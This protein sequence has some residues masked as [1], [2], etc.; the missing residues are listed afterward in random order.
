M[1]TTN[2]AAVARIWRGRTTPELADAY[3]AYS[4]EAGIEPLI[5][6]A[7]A[8]DVFREDREDET[9]FVTISYWESVEAMSAFAGADPKAIHHL[10]RDP[11]FLIELPD[12]VQI[13]TMPYQVCGGAYRGGRDPRPRLRRIDPYQE[14]PCLDSD[15]GERVTTVLDFPARDGLAVQAVRVDYEPGGYTAGTHRHPAGAYVYVVDGSVI[16]GIDEDEPF[17]LKAGDSFYEPPGA[18]HAVSRN[19][20]EEVPASLLA[21]FVLGD[22]REPDRLRARRAGVMRVV[23]LRAP[24]GPEQLAIEEAEQP[25]PG[26][27]QA[28]V[29]VHAAAITRDEL[30]WP[31]ERLPAIPSYELS[32]V[33]EEVGAD[34]TGVAVGDDVFALTPFDRDGVAADYAAVSA[35][36]LVG[37]PRTLEH[38]ESAAIPLPALSAWQGLFDHGR[39]AAGQRVLIHGAAG[40]V[41]AFA[42]QLARA[43]GA[44]VIGT[45]SAANLELV[46]RARRTRGRRRD[47]EVRGRRR[48]GRRGVRHRRRRAVA[49]VRSGAAPG[50][51]TGLRGRAAGRW[52]RVLHR[53]AQS[54]PARVAREAGRRRHAAAACRVETF[55]LTE[56]SRGVRAQPAT[57]PAR[58][59]R[60]GPMNVTGRRSR[61]SRSPTARSPARRPSSCARPPRSCCSTTPGASSCGP[62]CRPNDSASTATPNCSTSGRCSTTS[63]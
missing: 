26:P 52:R 10:E 15:S 25:R 16:F 23:R 35:E 59:G 44:H 8:V 62:R 41:G 58:Q 28:L 20:S 6:K 50:R 22:G 45:A 31:V 19:A 36:L 54:R 61:G 42:V 63:G 47:L 32:G 2:R 7:L 46:A 29:R 48:A 21:F 60:A 1:P 39:L 33:V 3:E 9:E 18:L 27:G 34:V 56:A 17:V 12:A 4:Y 13:L 53:R 11:E 38:A 14:A 40:A 51:A 43:H 49:T 55:P 57:G 5:E 37:K 24:G 30:Q